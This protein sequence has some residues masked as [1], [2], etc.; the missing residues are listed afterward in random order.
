MK[1]E[2]IET[3]EA[4]VVLEVNEKQGYIRCIAGFSTLGWGC[5]YYTSTINQAKAQVLKDVNRNI[6]NIDKT[7][8]SSLKGLKQISLKQQQKELF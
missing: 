7:N 2:I 1:K 4:K 3:P 6:K 8:I 5:R